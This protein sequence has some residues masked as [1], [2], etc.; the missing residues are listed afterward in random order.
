MKKVIFTI[1][2]IVLS[3]DSNS[4]NLSSDRDPEPLNRFYKNFRYQNN[5]LYYINNVRNEMNGIYFYNFLTDSNVL[6]RAGN[7]NSFS[8]NMDDSKIVYNNNTSLLIQNIVTGQDSILFNLPNISNIEWNEKYGIIFTHYTNIDLI[9]GVYLWNGHLN[10]IVPHTYNMNFSHGMDKFVYKIS[11]YDS[12]GKA[13][14]DSIKSYDLIT[15]KSSLIT[16]L[17]RSE[18]IRSNMLYLTNTEKILFTSNK[19]NNSYGYNLFELN[20][21]DLSIMMIIDDYYLLEPIQF[22]SNGNDVILFTNTN[23]GLIYTYQNNQ[24]NTLFRGKL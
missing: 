16:I 6:V 7:F 10:L 8:V 4:V 15:E 11:N 12:F 21:S 13:L 9:D 3:C 14:A 22:N 2:L 18:Y 17:N 19:N 1:F 24:I 20:I 23:D 5:R